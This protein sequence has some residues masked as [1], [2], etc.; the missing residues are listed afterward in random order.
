MDAV[1]QKPFT[2]AQLA[3]CLVDQV[4]QFQTQADAT[5]AANYDGPVEREVETRLSG[6]EADMPLV[7][8]D[9]LGQFRTLNRGRKGD[10]LKRVVD[11]Y[12]EHAPFA[13]GQ[14]RQHAAAGEAEACGSVAHSL[15]SMSLN[16][17]AVEVA[18]IAA[19]F[20]TMARSDGKVPE[21]N[22]LDALSDTV[23]RTLAA[24]ADETGE[25]ST[26]QGMI[27]ARPASPYP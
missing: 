7:D 16:I 22:L 8:P 21:L 13:C 23:E 27:E 15:K 17:G 5:V 18:K 26:G 10:F 19:A 25:K 9:T 2:I 3:Q 6:A 4:P 14:L 20:E 24:L 12:S 1:I 11:L